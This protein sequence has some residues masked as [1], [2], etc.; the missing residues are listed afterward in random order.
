MNPNLGSNIVELEETAGK[1]LLRKDD[2][3]ELEKKALEAEHKA[4][5]Y[6]LE[7]R[8]N[9]EKEKITSNLDKNKNS[10]I[11]DYVKRFPA[12]LLAHSQ[13]YS[14][15]TGKIL[16]EIQTIEA[17]AKE[18]IELYDFLKKEYV[19]VSKQMPK[20][21][22]EQYE[23]ATKIIEQ[24]ERLKQSIQSDGL[25]ADFL[26][27]F[28]LTLVCIKPQPYRIVVPP[29]ANNAEQG[30]VSELVK[31]TVL[32]S[33]CEHVGPQKITYETNGSNSAF[34]VKDLTADLSDLEQKI[35]EKFENK[36]LKRARVNFAGIFLAEI[37]DYAENDQIHDDQVHDAAKTA[38]VNYSPEKHLET[39]GYFTLDQAARFLFDLPD[40][41]IKIEKFTTRLR[42]VNIEETLFFDNTKFRVMQI[43][44][45]VI[46]NREDIEKFKKECMIPVNNEKKYEMYTATVIKVVKKN[47][48]AHAPIIAEIAERCGHRTPSYVKGIINSAQPI[49]VQDAV[50]ESAKYYHPCIICT[51]IALDP[52]KKHT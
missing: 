51:D 44:N 9:S 14:E 21:M 12:A 2:E 15:K 20:L 50:D 13:Q 7:L 33:L 45:N 29:E 18:A 48:D 27:D 5:L 11:I 4:A 34:V 30:F 6:A 19:Q 28:H 38:E 10:A 46:Y 16:E 25:P 23:D 41:E 22:Q 42:E 24:Y 43:Q 49:K 1:E 8:I 35:R 52:R 17:K 31:V 40:T 39:E 37:S 32:E 26:P 47:L 36:N 3:F